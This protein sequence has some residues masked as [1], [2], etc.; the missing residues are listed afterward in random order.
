MPEYVPVFVCRGIAQLGEHLPAIRPRYR[1]LIVIAFE[2]GLA[3]VAWSY[4]TESVFW[5]GLWV[6]S[7]GWT[8]AA[9]GAWFRSTEKLARI[10][11]IESLLLLVGAGLLVFYSTIIYGRIQ[12]WLGGGAP[13]RIDLSLREEVPFIAGHEIQAALLDETEH[14][15]Y[16]VHEGRRAVFVPRAAVRSVRFNPSVVNQVATVAGAQS[17]ARKQESRQAFECDRF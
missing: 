14:G 12:P 11:Q 13:L 1:V 9:F 15:F 3:V 2:L 7:V 10:V 17:Q 4:F 16:I 6:A 5:L 8:S